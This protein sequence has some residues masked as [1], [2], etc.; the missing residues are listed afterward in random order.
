MDTTYVNIMLVVFLVMA[1]LAIDVGYMY[2]SDEDLQHAAE[3]SSLA[4]ARGIKQAAHA[5]LQVNPREMDNVMRDTTQASARVAAMESATGAHKAV[6][7]IEVHNNNTNSMTT[8]NSMTVGYWNAATKTY[9]PGETPVNAIQVRTKRTAESESVGLGEM[10]SMIARITGMETMNFNPVAIAAIPPLARTNIALSREMCESGCSYPNICTPAE[11][12]LTAGSSAEGG[13]NHFAFTTL[14]VPVTGDMTL[15]AMICREMPPQDVCGRPVFTTL[16]AGADTLRDVE[17]MM[18]DPKFDDSNKEYD[19]K[20]GKLL[21]WWVIAPVVDTLPTKSGSQFE[22]R[23]VTRYALIRISRI[24]VPGA[25]GCAQSGTS[26][27]AP[28]EQCGNETGLFID[29]ISCV[30]CGSREMLQMPGLHP[31]IVQ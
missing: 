15:S 4:G 29:R 22:E 13:T 12:R 6:A 16:G 18:Y 7:L 24:C 1:A 30:G 14:A 9:T 21:G 20:S 28:A 10:G 25:S 5:Q 2:V 8:E 31:V 26:F 3:L 19:K 17:A 27:D 11:R 23:L